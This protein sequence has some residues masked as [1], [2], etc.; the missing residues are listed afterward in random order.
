MVQAVDSRHVG[1]PSRQR[2]Q[3][4]NHLFNGS[5]TLTH[6]ACAAAETAR[7][8]APGNCWRLARDCPGDYRLWGRQALENVTGSFAF[9]ALSRTLAASTKL[10]LGRTHT[11]SFR[12]CRR[13]PVTWGTTP[14][15]L[16]AVEPC[17][18][19]RAGKAG[20][21]CGLR[22]NTRYL[23]ARLRHNIPDFRDNYLRVNRKHFRDALRAWRFRRECFLACAAVIS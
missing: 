23:L 16:P 15:G 11:F 14:Q 21:L 1:Y 8:G 10:L 20:A 3:T 17:R 18:V 12:F 7:T 9:A 5:L 4:S 22:G 6:L 19:C 13:N 2:R